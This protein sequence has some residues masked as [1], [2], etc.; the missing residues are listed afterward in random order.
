MS[1]KSS[2]SL[3]IFQFV[4]DDFN[5]SF[6][7]SDLLADNLTCYNVTNFDIGWPM[8]SFRCIIGVLTRVI[9]LLAGNQFNPNMSSSGTLLADPDLLELSCI[10]NNACKRLTGFVTFKVQRVERANVLDIAQDL[11]SIKSSKQT[12]SLLTSELLFLQEDFL[13]LLCLADAIEDEVELLS[14]VDR[15]LLFDSD[16]LDMFEA[17]SL[18]QG[19]NHLASSCTEFID[20]ELSFR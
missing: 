19:T 14:L 3:K 12:A 9:C 18:G 20:K 11:V 16:F 17:L 1:L 13:K 5:F 4:L 8:F 15:S 10:C 7:P 2:S 6:V